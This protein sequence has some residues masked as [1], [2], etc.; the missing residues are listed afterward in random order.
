MHANECHTPPW[1]NPTVDFPAPTPFA[2]APLRQP[3]LVEPSLLY[4]PLPLH[5]V[6]PSPLSFALVQ[7]TPQH[8]SSYVQ[9]LVMSEILKVTKFPTCTFQHESILHILHRPYTL[10]PSSHT[11]PLQRHSLDFSQFL[12]FASGQVLVQSR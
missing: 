1:H 11:H 3:F 7:H 10:G 2:F 4:A 12:K 5:I 6:L 9:F 8:E